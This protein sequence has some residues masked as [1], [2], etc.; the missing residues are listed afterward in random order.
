MLLFL[1]KGVFSSG[2]FTYFDLDNF[3]K[4]CL[5]MVLRKQIYA[6]IL[7]FSQ[8]NLFTKMFIPYFL[9]P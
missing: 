3:A 4:D 5:Q 8:C 2:L 7:P 9:K 6:F 1:E